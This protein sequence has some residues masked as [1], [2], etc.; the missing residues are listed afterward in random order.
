MS[1]IASLPSD[2]ESIIASA[3]THSDISSTTSQLGATLVGT[4]GHGK[5]D[6]GQ[7]SGSEMTHKPLTGGQSH[8][9][10]TLASWKKNNALQSQNKVEAPVAV[11]GE[12]TVVDTSSEDRKKK[13]K[14]MKERTER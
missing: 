5:D 9:S 6:Q 13:E 12:V 10:K 4:T 7:G 2:T 1:A 3:S 14:E 8:L 11:A